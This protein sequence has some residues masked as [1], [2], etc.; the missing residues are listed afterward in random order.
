MLLAKDAEN[1]KDR[2]TI[3]RREMMSAAQPHRNNRITGR[4]LEWFAKRQFD[5]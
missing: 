5:G 3:Y 4:W 1:A 2:A